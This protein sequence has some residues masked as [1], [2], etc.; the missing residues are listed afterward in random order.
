MWRWVKRIFVTIASLI[1]L[2]AVV[3][4]VY[5]SAASRRD[6][7]STSPPGRLIDVGGHRLHLWCTGEG[8]PAVILDAGLGGTSADWGF[9]QPELTR[10]TRT[11]SYDRA[12]M[13]YSDAGPSPRTARRIALELSELL[14]RGGVDGPVVLVGASSGALNVRMFASDFPDRVAG[15]V[16]VDGSHEDQGLELPTMAR[17][18]PLL[19]TLGVLRLRGISLGPRIES[20]APATQP[21]ARATRFRTSGYHA[22]AD[23][24]THLSETMSEVR[25]SRRRLSV[26]LVVVTAGR[27][28]DDGWR[29][30]QRDLVTLSDGG[31][32]MIAE[33]SGHLVALGQPEVVVDAVRAVVDAARG[34]YA[35]ARRATTGSTCEA[36]YAGR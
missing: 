10:L 3:G 32:Q 17:F 33:Q 1:V 11:C 25:S 36:R 23:E 5:Q 6:L 9:V 28:T 19:S 26:P 20:L 4:V 29:A 2:A 8:A 18:V 24:I 12:G 13:G 22:A 34:R 7:A 30:L 31:C 15:L 14:T 21:F 35:S 27:G 16:F